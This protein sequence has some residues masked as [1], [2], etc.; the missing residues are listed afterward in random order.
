[1]L[2][3]EQNDLITQTGPG[4]TGGKFLRSYWHPI[5]TS[6]EMPIGGDPIPIR[7]MSEDLVLFRDPNDEL[8]LIGKHCPHRGTD[9]SYGRVEDGGIRCLYHGW[10]FDKNGN[11]IDQPAEP[12]GR[13]FCDKVKHPAYPVQEKGGAIWTY[14]G[15]GEPPLIP[16]FEFLM[17]KEES[18]L[19]FRVIQNC[20][21]LQGLESS[22]DPAHTTYLHRRPPGTPSE[23][24]F[25]DVGAL[26]GNEPPKID[27]EQTEFGTRIFALHNA[28][29]GKKYLRIN[30]YVYPC[31]ATPSTSTGEA[32]YQGR[33]YVPID[34]H[35]HCRFEFFYR[36]SA[37]LDKERL[38]KNRAENVG[39]DFRHVRRME[40]RYLQDRDELKRG[41][42]FGGMGMHFPSQDAFAIETQGSIQDR[43][44]ENLGSSDIVITAVRRALFN[45]IKKMEETGE[46]PFVLRKPNDDRFANFICTATYIGD[47]E[48]GPSF[49]KRA[50]AERAAE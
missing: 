46:A 12:E 9:L 2:S 26:R 11:C 8:G 43:T 33:W 23:R 37:V 14:M 21:W 34:D 24:S 35:S 49:C 50:L 6:E 30:N 4:T 19:A 10:L 39:A 20:N 1:M 13:K 18:R 17:A 48:D 32:G 27:I 16:D 28:P 25:T 7:I 42:S 15:E 38:Q 45:A 5:A 31:G 47:D 44:K 41:D 36:Y 29:G 40:N 3:K 22:A